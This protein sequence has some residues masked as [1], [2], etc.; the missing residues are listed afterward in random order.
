MALERLDGTFAAV[1][2][3]DRKARTAV[4]FGRPTKV[5]EDLVNKGRTTMTP[6][7]SRRSRVESPSPR[8][9]RRGGAR[10]ERRG[11]RRQ[12]DDSRARP[13][14]RGAAPRAASP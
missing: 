7:V 3:A 4:P 8:A 9:R 2:N 11:E 12:D 6:H 10:R 5:L 13:P 1:A 14:P